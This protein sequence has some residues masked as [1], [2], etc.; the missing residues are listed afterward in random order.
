VPTPPRNRLR[1]QELE[2]RC[3][4]SAD[5]APPAGV[6]V[7]GTD[8]NDV[9]A[10]TRLD[11]D[12]VQVTIQSFLDPEWT[13]PTGD[14]V[15]SY[16]GSTH[17]IVG[18]NGGAGHD[19]VQIVD[20]LF[21]HVL[22]E[23]TNRHQVYTGTILTRDP[24]GTMTTR[25]DDFVASYWVPGAT[26]SAPATVTDGAEIGDGAEI[27]V[28][29]DF[30]I[31]WIDDPVMPLPAPWDPVPEPGT[32]GGAMTLEGS[33]DDYAVL[34]DA[35]LMIGEEDGLVPAVAFEP[36]PDGD[37]GPDWTS[38]QSD[39]SDLWV[40]WADGLPADQWGAESGY[41]GD[42]SDEWGGESLDDWLLTDLEGGAG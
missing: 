13:Q 12:R 10:L 2:S 14:P 35:V 26:E 8:A 28:A 34:D 39:L 25:T 24:D 30:W 32:D 3:L 5:F 40:D 6:V 15:T 1:L 38:D 11:E 18:V 36:G 22:L 42:G 41:T 27:Q 4:L 17:E 19:R 23:G 31:D 7:P 29:F 16:E 33:A 9:I 37:V 20:P 21:G